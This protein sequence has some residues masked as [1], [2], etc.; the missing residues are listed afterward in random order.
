[1]A[2]S[3]TASLSTAALNARVLV[4]KAARRSAKADYPIEQK[5]ATVQ[6]LRDATRDLRTNARVI[7]S[8]CVI[9]DDSATFRKR[10]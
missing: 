4:A 1:M 9:K 3:K 6:K 10:R 2:K 7:K 5:L 8:G